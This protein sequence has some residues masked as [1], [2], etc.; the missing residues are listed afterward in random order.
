M[1]T[2]LLEAASGCLPVAWCSELA[3]ASGLQLCGLEKASPHDSGRHWNSLHTDA[4]PKVC[5]SGLE[6]RITLQCWHGVLGPSESQGVSQLSGLG[7]A[8]FPPGDRHAVS[9]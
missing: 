4:G 5:D 2:Y 7:L 1:G 3:G 6:H 9:A 8:S